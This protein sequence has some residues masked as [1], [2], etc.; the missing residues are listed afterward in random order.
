M[1][2][3][4]PPHCEPLMTLLECD[5]GQP[6]SSRTEGCLD[7]Q[8][9]AAVRMA[10]VDHPG[11]RWAPWAGL[12]RLTLAQQFPK[13]FSFQEN[14]RFFFFF[15][16]KRSLES[17]TNTLPVSLESG[18]SLKFIEMILPITSWTQ[19]KSLHHTSRRASH[20][21]L[22]PKRTTMPLSCS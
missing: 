2:G 19:R 20:K 6:K 13:A 18:N 21:L 5:E 14:L 22:C 17:L 11:V 1:S 16:K 3:S 8:T 4:P 12:L 7:I 9:A 15:C 10:P